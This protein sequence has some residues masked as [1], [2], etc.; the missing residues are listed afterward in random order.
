MEAEAEVKEEV[1]EDE[2]T[3]CGAARTDGMS[4]M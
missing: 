4:L 3:R 2:K 1:E